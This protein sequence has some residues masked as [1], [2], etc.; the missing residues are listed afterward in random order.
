MSSGGIGAVGDEGKAPGVPTMR[1]ASVASMPSGMAPL[2][3]GVAGLP[4]GEPE[5]PAGVPE[6]VALPEARRCEF[7][8]LRLMHDMFPPRLPYSPLEE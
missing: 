2:P 5:P 7:P 6:G 8:P 3:A 4:R 1:A